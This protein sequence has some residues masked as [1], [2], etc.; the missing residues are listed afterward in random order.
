MSKS[1]LCACGALVLLALAGCGQRKGMFSNATPGT[2]AKPGQ[3]LRVA[4]QDLKISW[5]PSQP[6]WNTMKLNLKDSNPDVLAE[7]L[8]RLPEGAELDLKLSE[9]SL[10]GSRCA[11]VDSVG[12]S[13]KIVSLGADGEQDV[14]TLSLKNPDYV[15]LQEEGRYSVRV[16]VRARGCSL[17]DYRF[18]VVGRD[19]VR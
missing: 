14:A 2:I 1:R 4:D 15:T 3:V 9:V 8:F 16:A 6:E 17:L 12:A 10:K 13:L 11:D 19:R 5:H 18:V 7:Y